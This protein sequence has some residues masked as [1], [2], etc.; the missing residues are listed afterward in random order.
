MIHKKVVFAGFYTSGKDFQRGFRWAP[1]YSHLKP[2]INSIK[3]GWHLILFHD[4][5]DETTDSE[6]VT[7][8]KMPI[9][10]LSVYFK[11]WRH[12]LGYL[13]KHP[14]IEC[15]FMVDS[16]D[17]VM[18]NDPYPAMDKG[19]IYVGAD[20]NPLSMQ[21]MVNTHG[22]PFFISTLRY[23]KDEPLLNCG[24]WGGYRGKAYSFLKLYNL[25][26][27]HHLQLHK[28]GYPINIETDIGLF[29]Y[30]AYNYFKDS[31]VHGALVHTRFKAYEDAST[32]ASWWKHK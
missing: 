31:I 27:D 5:F 4:C 6:T 13:D 3:P 14:E 7:H 15:F 23:Y 16:T 21:W 19:T 17:V 26:L 18:C 12:S 11:K 2:L 10:S 1:N 24:T 9:D 29:N 22:D 25:Y 30:I 32:T 28:H 8:I 20:V